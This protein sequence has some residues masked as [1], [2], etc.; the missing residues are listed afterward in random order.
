MGIMVLDGNDG[1]AQFMG[2]SR[3]IIARV[4]VAGNDGRLRFKE[5]RHTPYGLAQGFDR[6]YIGHIADVRRRIEQV[7]PADAETVFQFPAYGQ[8]ILSC[9]LA[10]EKGSGA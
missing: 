8:D 9:S 5:R 7:I 4:Q 10:I 3:R 6:A 1:Q 2:Y